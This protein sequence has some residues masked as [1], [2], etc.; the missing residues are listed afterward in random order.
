MNPTL[1]YPQNSRTTPYTTIPK[2]ETH[3]PPTYFAN[4]SPVSP[5]M[6]LEIYRAE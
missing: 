4:F 5:K 2:Q 6:N 1:Y 3:T